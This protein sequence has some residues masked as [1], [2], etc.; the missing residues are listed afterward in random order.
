M[1]TRMV[2]AKHA[3]KRGNVKFSMNN[4]SFSHEN[5]SK[6]KLKKMITIGN[7]ALDTVV[8]SYLWAFPFCNAISRASPSTL[9]RSRVCFIH[10]PRD[11]LI[12]TSDTTSDKSV[13]VE[14]ALDG[15]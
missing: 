15:N 4:E 7:G 6:W 3:L 10:R 12:L 9:S 1:V 5:H 11:G 8:L 2:N 13:E 14:T